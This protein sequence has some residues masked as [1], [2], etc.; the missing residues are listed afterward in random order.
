MSEGLSVNKWQAGSIGLANDKSSDSWV[1][2]TM[3]GSVEMG[4][5]YA[6]DATS[7]SQWPVS[8]RTP[9]ILN[10]TFKLLSQEHRNTNTYIYSLVE[11]VQR[12]L[13]FNILVV[14]FNIYC[15]LNGCL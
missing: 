14:F 8:K 7:N 10:Y 13:F 15:F 3:S 9:E 11:C 5:V 12:S 6:S 1:A 2:F 4:N